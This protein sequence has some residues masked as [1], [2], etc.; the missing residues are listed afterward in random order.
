MAGGLHGVVDKRSS[1]ELTNTRIFHPVWHRVFGLRDDS[2]V[3]PSREAAAFDEPGTAAQP[4]GSCG[5]A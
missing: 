3:H 2:T 4:A 5:A 1:Y